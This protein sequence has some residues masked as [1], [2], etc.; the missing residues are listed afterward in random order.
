MAAKKEV[1]VEISVLDIE[2]G[3]AQFFLTG[4][5]PMIYNAVAEKA[6]RELLLPWG[7]KTAADKAANLKHEPLQEYRNST[8]R[9]R[10][11]DRPTRLYFK[12]EAFKKAMGTAALDLPGTRKTEIG[13]LCWVSGLKVDIY[14][15]PKMLMSVV[16]SAD[17]N[18][19]PDIRTR[20]ILPEWCAFIEVNF[21]RPKLR[22]V[23]VSK[24][25]AA[26]GITVGIG[27]FRQEKGAGSY[28]QFKLVEPNDQDYKRILKTGG[29]V[30]QDAA[31]HEPAYY[32]IETEE[33]YTWYVEELERRGRN[34][35]AAK[36]TKKRKETAEG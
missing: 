15:V 1:E 21:V 23:T 9:Y 5:S 17:I 34:K 4:Q 29:R 27:D 22:D 19:T 20:A 16:R 33:L 12:P 2:Q 24:L 25:L 7:K 18:R 13:R 35:P 28:G 14:G 11:N 10:E 6:K 31:L 8:Y 32:D 3:R 26:A 30:A 36:K